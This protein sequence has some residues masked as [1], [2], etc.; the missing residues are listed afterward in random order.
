MLVCRPGPSQEMVIHCF[1]KN[2]QV[3]KNKPENHQKNKWP[4]S[5]EVDCFWPVKKT[6]APGK[7][8]MPQRAIP[9]CRPAPQRPQAALSPLA[10]VMSRLRSGNGDS[11]LQEKQ[12]GLEKQTGESP[13][14][15]IR[16]CFFGDCLGRQTNNQ[17]RVPLREY[18]NP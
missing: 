12:T 14:K 16:V 6:N 3:Q 8:N 17:I 4:L 15:Q 9:Y 18:E 10:A 1:K 2:K 13:E 7:E 11:L 5:T